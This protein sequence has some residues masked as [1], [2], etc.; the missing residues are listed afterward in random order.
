MA[1]PV[2][3]ALVALLWIPGTALAGGLGS[4]RWPAVALAPLMT[5]GL[6]S[7]GAIITALVGLR[8]GIAVALFWLVV[9]PALVWA[10][11]M[12]IAHTGRTPWR[13]DA[14]T[15][16]VWQVVLGLAVSVAL[17]SCIVHGGTQAPGYIPQ[18][19]DQIF[20][21][22]TV[23]SMLDSGNL[24]SLTAD[25]L[26]HRE[27][28]V[29]YPAAFHG[30]AATAVMFTGAPIV[31]VENSLLLVTAALTFPLG[32]MLMLNTLVARDRH[33]VLL[34]GVFSLA[35]TV[36]PWVLMV[37]GAVWAQVF[38]SA[39]IPAVVAV[40][41]WGVAQ[42]FLGKNWGSSALLFVVSVPAL[43]LAHSSALFAAVAAAV[44]LSLA[45]ALKHALDAPRNPR[46]WL[47]LAV[48]AVLA[49]LANVLG[50]LVAPAG[51]AKDVKV[52][53]PAQQVI[54]GIATSWGSTDHPSQVAGLVLTG[55][56][57][58]GA[59]L[60]FEHRKDWWLSATWA[61][62]MAITTLLYANGTGLVWQW[63][64]PWYNFG[65]RVE[66]IMA[67]FA[68]PLVV[69]GVSRMLHL[70]GRWRPTVLLIV[71]LCLALLPVMNVQAQTATK[72]LRNMYRWDS[73]TGWISSDE[74]RALVKLSAKMPPDAVV[75]TSP[76]RGG[77]YLYIVGTQHT[78]IPTEKS[79]GR[80]DKIVSK[81]LKD[82]ATDRTVCAAAKRMGI[83]YVITG[84]NGLPFET[85]DWH[86]DQAG[87][88]DVGESGGFRRVAYVAPYVLWSV[89]DCAA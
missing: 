34:S 71:L 3:L 74:V 33:L 61:S 20:H 83:S 46:Q 86:L 66:A 17:A 32:M 50:A 13:F 51:M 41:G 6:I 81:G 5:T 76:W 54:A 42:A 1:I 82:M 7:V 27:A 77:Q 24:S 69:L 64:W 16:R 79:S 37:R 53:L 15:V 11:R 39:F 43:F 62:F 9:V 84:G 68:V 31:V 89:P 78:A 45:Y 14:P 60:C 35:F 10:A 4:G 36:F 22:G 85:F 49:V 72:T 70:A 19:G 21:L 75:A 2:I 59:V 47:P 48:F 73:A 12:L 23:R 52:H 63:T 26:N 40:Y 28:P 25:G 18:Q 65:F 88:D 55:L 57:L 44:M 80:D 8:W 56:A 29:F 30:V 38:G 87:I 58:I 67:I